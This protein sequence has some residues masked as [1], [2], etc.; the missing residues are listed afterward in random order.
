MESKDQKRDSDG[1]D[2]TEYSAEGE[3]EMNIDG[4][5]EQK[6]KLLN[7]WNYLCE[8][9]FDKEGNTY[10]FIMRVMN[11]LRF[12]NDLLDNRDSQIV[13]FEYLKFLYIKAREVLHGRDPDKFLP[14]P[15]MDL[16]WREHILYT[17][18]Y[19]ELCNGIKKNL[20]L[21]EDNIIFHREY[22][23]KME[24]NE[25]SHRYDETMTEY[26]TV[27]GDAPSEWWPTKLENENRLSNF[28]D[29]LL[30]S[31]EVFYDKAEFVSNPDLSQGT[32]PGPLRLSEEGRTIKASC[33]SKP[34][35]GEQFAE[36]IEAVQFP[37][38]MAEVYQRE[39]RLPMAKVLEY[40]HEYKKYL[41]ISYFKPD[42][43]VPSGPVDMLWHMHV[44]STRN[45]KEETTKLFGSF[46]DHAPGGGSK[47]EKAE[48]GIA[49]AKIHTNLGSYFSD[50][51]NAEAWPTQ[52]IKDDKYLSLHSWRPIVRPQKD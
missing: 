23:T 38:G 51:F 4:T 50:G 1:E 41:W 6:E 2:T 35:T 29:S 45:Y 32:N 14:S 39:S 48:F 52:E 34:L 16:V 46:L 44:T 40:F 47:Q 18:K 27:F 11:I 10:L 43:A 5:E 30:W 12:N 42:S 26:K 7:V 36:K 21:P 9:Q 25:Y 13:M 3:M 28:Y 19:R 20:G 49:T 24:D 8:F 15:K 37:E 31:P 17:E 22:P 33:S